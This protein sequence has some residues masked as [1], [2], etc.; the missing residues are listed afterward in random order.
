MN[1]EIYFCLHL[2]E[3]EHGVIWGELEQLCKDKNLELL[4]YRELKEGHI[5]MYREVKLK[6]DIGYVRGYIEKE[7]L[8]E[9]IE[10]NPWRKN[11]EQKIIY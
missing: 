7:K 3:N 6:G 2:T 11:V 8:E 1:D 4:Y 10:H 9:H 5:P